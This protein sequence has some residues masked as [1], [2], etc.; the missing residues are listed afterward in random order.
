MAGSIT[1][2]GLGSGDERQLTLGVWSVL[3]EAE[4]IWLRTVDHPVVNWLSEQGLKMQSFDQYYEQHREFNDVYVAIVDALMAQAKQGKELVYAVPGHPMVA[5]Y[6]VVLLRERCAAEDVRLA[7]IGGESFLDQTFLRLGIDPV[8]GFQLL[9]AASM[10]DDLL[11]PKVHTIITQVYD[12]HTASDAKLTLMTLYPDDFVVVVAHRLGFEDERIISVPLY[13][14]DH[15]QGYGNHSLV[16]VPATTEDRVLNRTFAQLREI[17]HILRSP[18]GCP[19]DREQTHQSIRKNLIEETFE[20]V[21]TI[22]EDDTD[23]M[24]EE[25]GDLLLQIMLHSEMEEETGQF[26]VTD[27]IETIS[28]KLIRRHPH[29][30]GDV[31]AN[32]TEEVLTNWQAIKNEEKRSKGI[33]LDANSLMDGIPQ[34]LP[35]LYKATE[36]QKRAAKVG[37][38][39]TEPAP[40]LDKVR[41]ELTELIEAWQGKPIGAPEIADELGDL[42]FATVNLSRFLKVDAD[43]ALAGT[44]QKFDQRFRFIEQKI[45]ETGQKW[46]Q[47]SLEQMEEWW[48]LAKKT[49]KN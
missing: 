27:V 43:A 38:D 16:W 15:V 2:V 26:T 18:G 48:Q 7:I 10:K 25:L 8:N 6:T 35:A 32:S 28:E 1:V 5:E 19:W 13:E 47:I 21:E 42:L 11:Q 4:E 31:R 39:W 9:D 45:S 36:I 3:Q 14:L 29:V 17:V 23:A 44:I 33:D 30:F 24:C 20:V 22:D 46:E 41:E 49:K 12:V 34:A 40:V 37:F